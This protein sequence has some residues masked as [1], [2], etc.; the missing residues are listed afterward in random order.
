M[1][2]ERW[3]E[4][5]VPAPTKGGVK[6]LTPYGRRTWL[7]LGV[8]LLGA[9]VVGWL[10]LPWAGAVC[11][12]AFCFVL[13]FFRDPERGVKAAESALIAPADGKV[14]EIAEVKETHYIHGRAKKVAIFMTIADVH[15]NR[16]PCEGRVEWVRHQPGRF[17]NAL[18]P[19]AS[20]EN[21]CTMIALRDREKRQVLLKLV[22]GLIARRIICPLRPG[23]SLRRGQRLGMITFG[24]RV[25]VLLPA[26]EDFRVLVQL[27]QR[28][29]AGVTVL[30][31]W[32]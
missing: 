21:E 19:K 2:Y 3:W 12:L 1:P 27:G 8:V 11:G 16:S 4:G 22:A 6:I 25:E 15:V 17:L 5:A 20:I 29:R 14:V 26:R 31:K 28:V 7:P 24:S 32:M 9:T 30:G 18:G 13:W 23:D 10:Y